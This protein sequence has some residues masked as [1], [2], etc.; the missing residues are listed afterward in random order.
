MTLLLIYKRLLFSPF[1]KYNNRNYFILAH[2]FLILPAQFYL[3]LLI[4]VTLKH[5]KSKYKFILQN[6]M[7]SSVNLAVSPHQLI[8]TTQ[9]KYLAL[10]IITTQG[11]KIFTNSTQ[12]QQNKKVRSSA[13]ANSTDLINCSHYTRTEFQRQAGEQTLRSIPGSN[14]KINLNLLNCNT[15]CLVML[16]N[17]QVCMRM[18]LQLIYPTFSLFYYDCLPFLLKAL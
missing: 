7:K 10:L 3:D 17:S 2:F 18:I 14:C 1:V 5:N 6:F 9:Q 8:S 11:I 12:F 15:L 13:N 16:L 4:N